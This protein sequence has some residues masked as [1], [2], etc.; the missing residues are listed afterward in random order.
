[1]P[2]KTRVA[3]A[4]AK[5]PVRAAVAPKKKVSKEPIGT[6]I[7]N[8]WAL[9]ESK[10]KLEKEVEEISAKIT[11]AENII[12]D[13][14]DKEKTDRAASSRASVSISENVVPQVDDWET[15]MNEVVIKKGLTHLVERRASVTGCREVWEQGGS[16]PGLKPFIKR[17]LNLRTIT[18]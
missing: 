7:D 15:F 12:I 9:R 5:K 18:D 13:R 8:V 4:A 10:R 16:L 11:E 6:L 17:K 14:L 3:K 2:T 1:M